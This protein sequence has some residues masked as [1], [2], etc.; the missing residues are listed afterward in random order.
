MATRRTLTRAALA[1]LAGAPLALAACAD[2]DPV[3]EEEATYE[4]GVTDESG[5]ELIVREADEPAV[6]VDLPE[7]EMTAGTGMVSDTGEVDTT[8]QSAEG[9][10]PADRSYS[11]TP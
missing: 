10:A 4:T 7:T 9:T 3:E 2:A 11:E 5:G 6:A 1:L 8:D